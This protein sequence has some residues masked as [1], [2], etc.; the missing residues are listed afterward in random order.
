MNLI[1]S[2]YTEN[3][4]LESLQLMCHGANQAKVKLFEKRFNLSH[5]DYLNAVYDRKCLTIQ[6]SIDFFHQ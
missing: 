5:N 2:I 3:N 1:K 6:R 4:T